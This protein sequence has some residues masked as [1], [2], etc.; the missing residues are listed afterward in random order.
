MLDDFQGGLAAERPAPDP[1]DGELVFAGESLGRDIR[2]A[3][4]VAERVAQQRAA[5]RRLPLHE[6]AGR[7]DGFA[8]FEIEVR[9]ALPA[10]D[11]D[12]VALVE[13]LRRVQH[14]LRF[15]LALADRKGL[16]QVLQLAGRL[17]MQF[18]VVN[19]PIAAKQA[20][21]GPFHRS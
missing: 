12:Q 21:C 8:D 14:P 4:H 7:A 10:Q 16:G 15:S 19:G 3:G 1:P 9:F 20:A 11:D 2:F 5:A 18:V 6:R 17:L 13:R